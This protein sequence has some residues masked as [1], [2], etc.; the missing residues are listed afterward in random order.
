MLTDTLLADKSSFSADTDRNQLRQSLLTKTTK[1][2]DLVAA[3]RRGG[4]ISRDDPEQ[5][6]GSL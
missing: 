5:K 2:N 1:Q 3:Q 6:V 4:D